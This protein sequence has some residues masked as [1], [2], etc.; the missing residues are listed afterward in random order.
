MNSVKIDAKECSKRREDARRA[1]A[2][3]NLEGLLVCSRG[4]GGL[5]RYADVFYFSNYYS[6]FPYIPD[7]PNN[8]SGRAHPF[9]IVPANSDDQLIVDTPPDSETAFPRGQI[10]CTELVVQAVIDGLGAVGMDRGRVGL[11]GADVLPAQWYWDL[12]AA[13]P[14]VEWVD[15]QGLVND[16]RKVKSATE[17]EK[18]RQ[19]AVIG[20]RVVEAM[21]DSAGP[22]VRHGEVVAAGM[23]VL[24]PAGGQLYNCFMA[25][26][27]GGKNAK[28]VGSSFPTWSAEEPIASGDWLTLGV[29]G[30][31]EGYVFDL[32]RSRPIGSPT[33]RQ[34][35]VF[36]AAI[37]V[38]E[39]AID[40]I[41]PGV[42]AQDI[43][44][45]GLSRQRDLGFE[46][47]G[48]FSGLG[49]GLGVGWDNPWLTLESSERV[50]AGMVLC[51]ERTIEASG[52][53]GDFEE[54]VLVT[55]NGTEKL[56]DARIRYW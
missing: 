50:Q 2:E 6:A 24:L 38:V 17:I 18:I 37:E 16:I 54:T 3:A 31:L 1:S 51:I 41:R 42:R 40:V 56:T 43:A 46:V 21:M 28:E 30:V 27:C 53:S 26:G 23:D 19:A 14:E 34:V 48:S 25:S 11:V 20:S 8:W 33:K 7:Q 5:D 15:A 49:H 44:E 36:E 32:A 47:S 55:E 22:G 9:L 29:S 4:G 35:E 12:C 52:C 10:T 45:A 13:L 39:A